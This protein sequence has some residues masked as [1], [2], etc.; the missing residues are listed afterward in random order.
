MNTCADALH[1]AHVRQ[2]ANSIHEAANTASL[3]LL[4]DVEVTVDSLTAYQRIAE[5]LLDEVTAL[6][7]TIK[8]C[9]PATPIDQDKIHAGNLGKSEDI[10]RVFIGIM[11]DK[12][13][14][15]LRDK[16]LNGDLEDSVVTEYENTIALMSRLHDATTELRWAILEHDADL[17]EPTGDV[18]KS[19]EEVNQALKA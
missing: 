6:G 4:R 1:I 9:K 12:K 16:S 8:S 11:E 19:A 3:D 7:G 15:A 10:I 5:E 13:R 17:E 2:I 18:Y 14:S